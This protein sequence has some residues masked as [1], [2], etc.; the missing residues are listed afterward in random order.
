[1][2]EE[3]LFQQNVTFTKQKQSNGDNFDTLLKCK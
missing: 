3:K 1:M 2:S